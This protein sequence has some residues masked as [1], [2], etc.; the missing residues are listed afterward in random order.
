MSSKTASKTTKGQTKSAKPITKVA[1]KPTKVTKPTKSVLPEK[2]P[3]LQDRFQEFGAKV[4]VEAFEKYISES[5]DADVDVEMFATMARD[6]AKQMATDQKTSPRTVRSDV[7]FGRRYKLYLAG[8][9]D[10][11]KAWEIRLFNAIKLALPVDK[12]TNSRAAWNMAKVLA[13]KQKPAIDI[14]AAMKSECKSGNTTPVSSDTEGRKRSR[15]LSMYNMWMSINKNE[16]PDDAR[17]QWKA[18]KESVKSGD[19]DARAQW[20]ALE[21]QTNARNV[22]LGFPD[23]SASDVSDSD[24]TIDSE[25]EEPDEP[26]ALANSEDDSDEETPVD[27]IDGMLD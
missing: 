5:G 8:N 20:K 2:R 4:A 15:A 10:G 24:A 1:A 26:V 13:P 3:S 19:E 6:I 23:K 18:L 7:E 14:V 11:R 12:Q 27:E 21:E 25:A 22:E 16:K 17:A 9:T